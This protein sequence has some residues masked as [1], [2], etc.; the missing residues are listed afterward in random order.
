MKIIYEHARNFFRPYFFFSSNGFF[1][2]S[3]NSLLEEHCK[4][5]KFKAHPGPSKYFPKSSFH[6]THKPTKSAKKNVLSE[7]IRVLD[8]PGVCDDFYSNPLDWS[9]ETNIVSVCLGP[10]LYLWY[11]SDSSIELLRHDQPSCLTSKFAPC[12]HFLAMGC[13]SG[14]VMI[15]DVEKL[16]PCRNLP[17]TNDRVMTI[18]WNGSILAVGSSAGRIQ[19]HDSRIKRSLVSQLISH[20]E[21][22]CSLKFNHD[23]HFLASG[24]NDNIV[25]V[26]ENAGRNVMENRPLRKYSEHRAAVKALDWS[27]WLYGRRWICR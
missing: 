19:I 1:L 17:H 16:A 14:G 15:W 27:P 23:G 9:V 10:A 12:G 7:P 24:G 8:A 2:L 5:F 20:E 6:A 22:I 18:D 11:G 3:R 13:S 25:C 4:V 21:E 26:W